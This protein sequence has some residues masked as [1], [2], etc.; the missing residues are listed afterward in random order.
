MQ[1]TFFREN[2]KTFKIYMG[3]KTL[4]H[5][6]ETVNSIQ[7]VYF[8]CAVVLSCSRVYSLCVCWGGGVRTSELHCVDRSCLVLLHIYGYI[9]SKRAV[10]QV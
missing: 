2:L 9:A 10:T 6:W 1:Y 3:T 5:L 4:F 8:S 7:I